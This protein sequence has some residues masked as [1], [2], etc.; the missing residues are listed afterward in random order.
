MNPSVTARTVIHGF[1]TVIMVRMAIKIALSFV[2]RIL[3]E[4]VVRNLTVL[5][6]T[7]AI[8]VERW[9]D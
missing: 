7:A 5:L 2:R 4:S 9:K 8:I 1:I 3:A 6:S